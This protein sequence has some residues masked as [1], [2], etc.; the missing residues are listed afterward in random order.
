M[1][2]DAS[3]KIVMPEDLAKRFFE[4]FGGYTNDTN[5]VFFNSEKHERD[6]M[7]LVAWPYDRWGNAEVEEWFGDLDRDDFLFVMDSDYGYETRGKLW[8]NPFDVTPLFE[9]SF[10]SP[11]GAIK[12]VLS[13][14]R[15]TFG[16]KRAKEALKAVFEE[17]TKPKKQAAPR[18]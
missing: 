13:T 11:E 5:S 4:D 10:K 17:E 16:E 18:P 6:G 3:V 15:D 8:E 7:V 9:V 12:S 1:G 2:Y 14:I